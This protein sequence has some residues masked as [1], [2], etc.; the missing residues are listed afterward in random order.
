[1]IAARA[2]GLLL[3]LLLPACGHASDEPSL[4][5]PSTAPPGAPAPA[6]TFSREALAP[7][8]DAGA[9]EPAVPTTADPAALDEI[10][11]AAPRPSA[12]APTLADASDHSALLGTDTGTADAGP[13]DARPPADPAR[14]AKI[15]IGK[16]TAE[17][18]MASAAIER[19]A[20]AQLYWALVQGCRDLDGG[21]LPPEVVHVEL[22]LDHEGYIVP[23]TILAFPKDPRFADAARCMARELRATAFRMPAAARGTPMNVKLDVP[24]VD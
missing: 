24:S 19:G 14:T 16:V 1:V 20:R 3:L 7:P 17:P 2:S 18:G 22:H 5:S 9:T 4:A 23:A 15:R 8:G 13:G 11:A 21:V 6:P 10:L 12:S